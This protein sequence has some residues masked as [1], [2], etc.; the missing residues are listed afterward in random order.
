MPKKKVI[1]KSIKRR[2]KTA[3]RILKYVYAFIRNKRAK[4]NCR[5]KNSFSF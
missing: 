5:D 2:E 4:A 3:R 1:D